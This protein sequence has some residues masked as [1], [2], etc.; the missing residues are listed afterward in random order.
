MSG[1]VEDRE[2]FLT[3]H[4]WVII[5]GKFGFKY[6]MN[7]DSVTGYDLD[8]AHFIQTRKNVRNAEKARFKLL[9]ENLTNVELYDAVVHY[10]SDDL[11]EMKAYR[12]E[13][14]RRLKDIKFLPEDDP[15]ID[16]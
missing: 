4:G 12:R 15:E 6:Y 7:I 2:K 16:D 9:A 5:H 10:E 11:E 3:D 13:L 14:Q 1:K 8:T